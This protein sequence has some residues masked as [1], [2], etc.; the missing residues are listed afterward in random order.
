MADEREDGTLPSVLVVEDDH[1]TR[2]L[3]RA[4]LE[5]AG[6]DVHTATNGREALSNIKRLPSPPRLI[7]VDLQMPVMDGWELIRSLQSDEALKA[8][9]VGVQSANVDITLPGGIAFVLP[10]P[11]DVDSLLALVRHHCGSRVT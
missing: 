4:T 6:F 3:L 8:I 1:D 5:G 2:V 10:K 9:P 7:V 11:V